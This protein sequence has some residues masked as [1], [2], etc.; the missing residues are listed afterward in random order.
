MQRAQMTMAAFC[1]EEACSLLRHHHHRGLA[2]GGGT[3]RPITLVLERPPLPMQPHSAAPA[4]WNEPGPMV[5]LPWRS[6]TTHAGVAAVTGGSSALGVRLPR[7]G[8]EA[9]DAT[10]FNIFCDHFCVYVLP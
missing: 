6:L 5:E 2:R 1:C 4:G 8:F 3:V 7:R 10:A 9:C